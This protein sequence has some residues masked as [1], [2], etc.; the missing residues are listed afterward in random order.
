MADYRPRHQRQLNAGI[1]VPGRTR[2]SRDCGP[3]TWSMGVDFQTRG[4]VVPSM[5]QIRER[6]NVEGPAMTG[7]R[8]AQRAI[9]S[10]DSVRGRMPLRFFIKDHIA[11]VKAAVDAG[12]FV[13][14]CVSY[15][16]FNELVGRSGDPNFDGNHMFGVLGERDEGDEPEWLLFDALDDQRRSGIPAGPRWIKRSIIVKSLEAYARRRGRCWAGVMGG[17]QRRS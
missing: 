9:E 12:K 8:D 4:E 2:G 11:D 10:Y 15:R 16:K 5:E 7:I 17:G 14:C 6:G 3:R 1:P 13:V